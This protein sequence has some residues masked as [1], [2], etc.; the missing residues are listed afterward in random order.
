MH[1]LNSER[2]DYLRQRGEAPPELAPA[3]FASPCRPP[4]RCR[5]WSTRA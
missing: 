2:F 1:Y 3:D 4:S 5:A